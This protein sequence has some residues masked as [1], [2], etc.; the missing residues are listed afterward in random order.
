[1]YV[2]ALR[3]VIVPAGSGFVLGSPALIVN[4][5]GIDTRGFEL[6]A[7][8]TFAGS[9]TVQFTYGLQSPED[10]ATGARLPDVPRH[11][12]RIAAIVPAGE[13]LLVS[14]SLSYRGGWTRAAGDPRADL[15][16]YTLVDVVVR[17]R[18]FHPRFEVAGS[19][20]N[21]FDTR[22]ADPSPLGGLPGDYPRPGRAAYL[23]L[24]YRF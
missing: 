23:K 19:I 18:N 7:S 15:D 3:D 21:I 4:A 2:A 12:V 6:E 22:Y 24:K 16:G 5:E 10:K 17:G 1:V 9:R 11:L 20:Q 13:Y 14:P 8:R